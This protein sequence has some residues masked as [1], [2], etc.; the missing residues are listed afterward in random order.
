MIRTTG[1]Q[2]LLIVTS[3]ATFA[4]IVLGG[5]VRVTESGL[6]CP[7]WPRCH[8]QFIPPLEREVLIEYSHRLVAMTV[9]FL[10]L[11]TTIFAWRSYRSEPTVLIPASL[12]LI[13]LIV[14]VLLGAVT[15]NLEL[16]AE[17]VA[18]HLGVALAL[19]ATLLTATVATFFLG[20]SSQQ[21]ATTGVFP[22]LA[23]LAAL[24][25][26]ALIL[27]GSYVTGAGAGLAFSDWP[28]FNGSLL[29]EGGRLANI[30]FLHRMAAALVGLLVLAL[31]IQAWRLKGSS[32]PLAIVA[33]LIPVLY[34]AQVLVGAANVWS[35]LEPALAAAHLGIAAAIWAALVVLTAAAYQGAIAAY[36]VPQPTPVRE[37]VKES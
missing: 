34:M 15:V 33:T 17:I 31:A 27:T 20:A 5:V 22:A 23:L 26:F 10:I 4:L 25:S 30:H 19:L 8:G 2:K 14:Q 35:R 36:R 21:W 32:S 13:L 28:L 9:G 3:L 37:L 24:C 6:G 16:P 29:P 18:A 1:F 11:A 7:D 12:A